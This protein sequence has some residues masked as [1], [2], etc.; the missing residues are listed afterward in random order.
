MD[1]HPRSMK[2]PRHLGPF[3]AIAA[4]GCSVLVAHRLEGQRWWC[5]C[6]ESGLWVSNVWT[7][8]CSRHLADAYTLTHVSHGLIFFAGLAW[9][10]PKWTIGWRLAIGVGIAAAWEIIEN[11][12][13]VINRYRNH[14]MSVEY[15]GDSVAN[16]LGDI[17]ACVAGFEI[18]RRFGL[19]VALAVFLALELVLAFLIRDNLTLS[20]LMLIHPFE[21]IKAWQMAGR[22][23]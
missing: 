8:H 14:T 20:T 2:A 22:G 17:L 10:R 3:L 13:F 19:W 12:A 1:D 21:A 6:G 16:S 11:S 4:T 15:L 23:P 5:A 9:L 18:A 7:K